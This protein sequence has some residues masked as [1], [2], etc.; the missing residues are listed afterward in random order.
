MEIIK[1]MDRKKHAGVGG[2]QPKTISSRL[3]YLDISSTNQPDWK[4]RG[5]N[6]ITD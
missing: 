2:T 1:I 4:H 5:P 3:L 6:G